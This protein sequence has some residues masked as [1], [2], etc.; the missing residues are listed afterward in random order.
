[1]NRWAA[2]FVCIAMLT[3]AR[4]GFAENEPG[5]LELSWQSPPECPTGREIRAEA[6]RLASADSKLLPSVQAKVTIE[7][8]GESSYVLTLTTGAAGPGAIQTFRAGSCRA[9]AQAAAVTLALLLNPDPADTSVAS[10]SEASPE[11]RRP[12][13]QP[14]APIRAALVG[15]AGVQ[16]GSLPQMGPTLGAELGLHDGPAS[17]W[18]GGAYGPAQRTMIEGQPNQVGGELALG[19]G[20]LYGCWAFRV[21]SPSLNLCAGLDFTRI[22][23]RGVGVTDERAGAVH[24]FSALGGGATEVTLHEN[25]KLRLGAFVATPFSHPA[26][27]VENAGTVHKPATVTANLH[28]G[29]GVL[30]P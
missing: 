1:M 10:S 3:F 13:R 5:G 30:W 29:A 12:A 2:S 21:R 17:L 28:A 16:L 26:A 22:S 4:V 20:M 15:L 8:E 6:L 14:S 24:W 19:R 7:R 18:L 27:F 9:V 11:L 25:I 23:G